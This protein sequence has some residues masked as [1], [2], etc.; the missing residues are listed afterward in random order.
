MSYEIED[1]KEQGTAWLKKI[2]SR[3]WIMV[4]VMSLIAC[5]NQYTNDMGIAVDIR[6]IEINKARHLFDTLFD[7]EVNRSPIYQTYLGIKKDYNKWDDLSQAAVDSNHSFAKTQLKTLTALKPEL[8]DKATRLSYALYKRKLE[9]TIATYEWRYY[10]YPVNQQFGLHSQ[11]PAFLI[12]MHQ[13]TSVKDAQDY[14]SRLNGVAR[15]FDQ[16]IV[17]LEIRKEKG[18]I[19]PKF[20]FPHVI[21]DAKNLLVGYPFTPG[22]DSTLMADIRGKV[23]ELDIREN[24]KKQLIAQAEQSLIARV[25]PAYTKLINYLTQLEKSA[26]TDEGV[27]RFP[28]GHAFYD[29]MLQQATTTDFTSEKI[30]RIGLSEVQRIQAEMKAIMET[31]GFKGSL[32]D[33]FTFMRNDAQFYYP[34]T[35]AGRKAYLDK[36]TALID[37]LNAQLD[38]LFITKP[39]AE[40]VVKE[41]EPFREESAGTAFYQRPA[42]DGSRPAYYYVNLYDMSAIPKYKMEALAYHEGIPG[43]HMQISIAQEAEEIPR[44]RKFESYTAY[45]EGW[46][47]YAEFVPKEMGYYQDPYADFGRLAMELW[48]ACRLVVDTGLHAKRWTREQAIAYLLENTPNTESDSIKAIERYIV[49]PSQATAYKI[50]MLKI[51]TLRAKAK[52]ALGPLYDMREFHEVVLKNGAVPLDVLDVLIDDWIASKKISDMYIEDSVRRTEDTAVKT[53]MSHRIQP[54]L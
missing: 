5:A 49:M 13:V 38:R 16:L 39:K 37:A 45:I 1:N 20:V 52:K 6:T 12:N 51:Q 44:F 17:G 11:V 42:P 53:I 29:F 22:N 47:L 34:E 8:L 46:A 36:T 18:I 35:D 40:L 26:D 21:R 30:H 24:R 4:I 43:H 54:E 28:S 9:N 3:I 32:Q 15:L 2:I 41:V 19:A 25:A 10:N 50:G 31:V 23:T 33:F 27:W 7:A 48:R 14:I